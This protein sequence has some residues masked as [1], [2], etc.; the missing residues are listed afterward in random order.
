MPRARHIASC[1]STAAVYE[2]RQHYWQWALIFI[3][4]SLSLSLSPALLLNRT[5]V[6]LCVQQTCSKCHS[7]RKHLPLRMGVSNV[8]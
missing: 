8:I 3:A 1:P 2:E 7:H 4:L 5:R 6:W